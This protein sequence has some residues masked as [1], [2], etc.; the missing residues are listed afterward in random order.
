MKL[1]DIA[2]NFL[3]NCAEEANQK[4][5]ILIIRRC[6]ENIGFLAKKP[7]L[8]KSLRYQNRTFELRSLHRSRGNVLLYLEI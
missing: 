6:G 4:N 5:R 3:L 1:P 8:Q 7:I 2:T